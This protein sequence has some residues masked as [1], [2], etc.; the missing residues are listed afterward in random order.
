MIEGKIQQSNINIQFS[1]LWT[2]AQG[3]RVFKIVTHS[4]KVT[5]NK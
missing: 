1:I 2:N 3:E 4:Q 5:E